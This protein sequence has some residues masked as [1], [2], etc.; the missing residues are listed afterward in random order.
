M[1]PSPREHGVSAAGVLAAPGPQTGEGSLSTC[2]GA[3]REEG[4]GEAEEPGLEA[5]TSPPPHPRPSIRELLG[6][7]G[8]LGDARWSAS[9]A[10]RQQ[11]GH[12]LFSLLLLVPGWSRSSFY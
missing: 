11:P 7:P 8:W 3:G 12:L 10:L 9:L 4:E 5:E 2:P 6:L 1:G